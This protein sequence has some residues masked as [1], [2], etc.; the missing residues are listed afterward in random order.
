MVVN[1]IIE[2]VPSTISRKSDKNLNMKKIIFFDADGILWYPEKT[3]QSCHPIWLYEDKRYKNH[4][5]HLEM[6]PQ[7]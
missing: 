3:K 2:M 1:Y 4:E 6:I 5:D 7:F